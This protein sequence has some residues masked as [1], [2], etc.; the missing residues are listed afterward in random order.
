MSEVVQVPVEGRVRGQVRR[1]PSAL[2]LRAPRTVVALS[3][4]GDVPT[5]ISGS[6]V[7]LWEEFAEPCSVDGV[8]DVLA[9]RHGVP[10]EQIRPDVEAS[11]ATL[12]SMG[13]LEELE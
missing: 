12:V 11:I 8:L 2:W 7:T 3:Q 4:R 6:G 10:I 1:A 9:Q 13:L 5:V